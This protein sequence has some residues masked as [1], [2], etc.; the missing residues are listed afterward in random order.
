MTAAVA[1]GPALAPAGI[2]SRTARPRLRLV[3]PGERVAAPARLAIRLNRR[4][5]LFITLTGAATVL[6]LT[7]GHD[8]GQRRCS[9][10]RSRHH[11]F[12]RSDPV[13]GRCCPTAQPAGQRGRGT[14][15]ACQRSEHLSGAR[16]SVVADSGMPLT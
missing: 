9:A 13:R 12:G 3:G 2:P 8:L 16:R 15:P 7:V 5:R 11:G 4:G 1:W 14:H 10:D 6:S